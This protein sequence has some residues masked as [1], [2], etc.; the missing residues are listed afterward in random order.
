MTIT[1]CKDCGVIIDYGFEDINTIERE[2]SNVKAPGPDYPEVDLCRTCH[3]KDWLK[4]REDKV[5][6]G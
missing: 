3:F 1:R 2:L 6:K 5:G 4:K